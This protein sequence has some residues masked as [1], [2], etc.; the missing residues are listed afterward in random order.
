MGAA[1][2]GGVG[3]TNQNVT[4]EINGCKTLQELEG[5]K[6]ESCM[7]FYWWVGYHSVIFIAAVTEFTH[8]L[9][10]SKD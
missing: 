6:F 10:Q 5:I 9:K 3:V 1:G 2:V 8:L 7:V 4:L